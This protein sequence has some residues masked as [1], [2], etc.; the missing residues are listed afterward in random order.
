MKKVLL[1]LITLKLIFSQDIDYYINKTHNQYKHINNAIHNNNYISLLNAIKGRDVLA[2]GDSLTFGFVPSKGGWGKS[3]IH[4]YSLELNLLLNNKEIFL[5]NNNNVITNGRNGIQTDV[6]LNKIT[7]LLNDRLNNK[8][9]GLVIILGGTNDLGMHIP[10]RSIISNLL[11]IHHISQSYEG[12]FKVFTLA[13]TIPMADWNWNETSRIEVNN[14]LRAYSKRCPNSVALLDMETVFDQANPFNKI[15][16][17]EDRAHFSEY[18]Y[19]AIG[20]LL[21]ETIK[22]HQ[23]EKSSINNNNHESCK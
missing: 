3:I 4:P 18:G 17:N 1:I 7:L 22:L 14:E 23:I 21:Y 19:D 15:Y 13:I 2:F 8:N 9:L 11:K 16:W 20:K 6:M 10:T 5:N 12:N